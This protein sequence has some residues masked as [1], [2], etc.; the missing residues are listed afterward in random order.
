MLLGRHL[1]A[2]AS[3][4]AIGL[5]ASIGADDRTPPARKADAY[6]PDATDAQKQE[7]DLQRF[8]RVDADTQQKL[9]AAYSFESLEDRLK[10]DPPGRKRLAKSFPTPDLELDRWKPLLRQGQ[11]IPPAA[12]ATLMADERLSRDTQFPRMQALASLHKLEVQKFVTNPGFGLA[13]MDPWGYRGTAETAPTDWSEA[14]RGEEVILPKTGGFFDASKDKNGPTLPS[15]VA[16]ANFHAASAHEFARPD[17][18]GLVKDKAHVAGFLP[19]TLESVPDGDTRRRFDHDNPTKDKSGRITGYPLIERW[20]TRKTELI[21]L[22][23]HGAPVVYMNPDNKLPTMAGIKDAKTRELSEFESA[24][25]KDVAAGKEVVVVDATTNQIRMV[26]A[27]RMTSACMRC[28]DGK[29][30]DLLGAFSYDLV[31]VPA[32][33]ARQK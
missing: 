25:L 17:S 15:T 9:L 6:P 31:R 1:I 33:I 13:R 2:V 26:G 23:M 21:G 10:F 32:Y 18:W 20:A 3:L 7:T 30:G 14:D 8:R 24:G 4:A 29:Q 5:L 12:L 16:L 22:L 11:T 27:I 28:H 19:H